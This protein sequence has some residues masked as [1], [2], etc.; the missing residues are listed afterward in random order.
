MAQTPATAPGRRGKAADWMVFDMNARTFKDGELVPRIHEIRP[1]VH[2]KLKFNEGTPMPEADA[3]KFLID[4]AFKV[5]SPDGHHVPA[6]DATATQRVM[7]NMLK[8]DQVIA[9]L[10]ELTTEALLTRAL[11]APGAPRFTASSKRET[12]IEF[13]LEDHVRAGGVARVAESASGTDDADLE[14]EDMD[15]DELDKLMSKGG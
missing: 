14:L 15:E 13:L 4:P 10:S 8:P 5:F 7:P 6:L 3:R 9:Q 1:G 2:Y 12:L 11:V